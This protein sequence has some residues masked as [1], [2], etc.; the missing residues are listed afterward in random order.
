MIIKNGKKLFKI[1]VKEKAL[2][3]NKFKRVIESKY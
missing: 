1:S 2:K 3:G